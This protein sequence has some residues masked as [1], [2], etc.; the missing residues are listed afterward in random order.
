MPLDPALAAETRGWLE[1]AHD[2]LEASR[3]C[4]AHPAP[5]CAVAAFL[6]QQAAE[7]AFK[8]FLTLHQT[9]FEKTHNLDE[10]GQKCAAIDGSLS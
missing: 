2:D 3:R 4:L 5:L 8:G 9:N 6:A 1:K 10:L 7:K